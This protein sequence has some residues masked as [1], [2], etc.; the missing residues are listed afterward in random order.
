MTSISAIVITPDALGTVMRTLD[1]L[2]AQTVHDELEVVLVGPEAAVREAEAAGVARAFG[3]FR[4]VGIGDLALTSEARAAGIRA[5]TSPV[6]VLTEDHCW[7][8]PEW[9]EALL[10]A[11][12]G[13]D[14]VVGPAVVNANPHT[15]LS[16]ANF[17]VEYSEWMF[18]CST[19]TV[20]HLPGHNSSYT[21][22]VL[23]ALG[24]D[25]APQ[26]EAESLLHWRLHAEGARLSVA[27]GAITRHLNF[28]QFRPSLGVRINSGRLFAG[29]RR[30]PWPRWRSLLYAGGSVLIPPLRFS[31][32]IGRF[33]KPGRA[34]L[35]PW[36]SYPIA[37]GLL[38]I[39]AAGECLGYLFGPGRAAENISAIDFHR[40]AFLSRKDRARLDGSAG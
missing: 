19:T 21:R 30:I 8:E 16:W 24:P 26:L 5:A 31:R 38:V 11:H 15:V 36:P 13:G 25:L 17:L 33:R 3:G 1:C 22:D 4:S 37:F 39:D 27:P 20:A 2:R 18:P 29:M 9:A 14:T 35:V 40:E 28:S 23:M 12:R 6:V 32:I 34:A 10:R 7:P